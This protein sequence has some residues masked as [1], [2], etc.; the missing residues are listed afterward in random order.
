MEMA[1]YG[2]DVKAILSLPFILAVSCAHPGVVEKHPSS[3][4]VTFFKDYVENDGPEP[5]TFDTFIKACGGDQ[6]ALVQI[7]SDYRRFG[8]GD[9]E[10]WGDVP[11][12]ILSEL[13]DERFSSFVS[14]QETSIQTS[15][16][17]WLGS[18]GSN[19]FRDPERKARYPRMA[20]IQEAVF[21]TNPG[22]EP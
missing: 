13:G 1:R 4:A 11:D 5:D 12:V 14:S 19:L 18:P 7:F 3:E 17:R 22:A 6:E 8:S 21:A 15:A 16:V 20:G 9:N 10:A 2:R